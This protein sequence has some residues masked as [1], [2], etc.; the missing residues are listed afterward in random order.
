MSGHT[1]V[2]TRT[3]LVPPPRRRT[4]LDVPAPRKRTRLRPRAALTVKNAN[5]TTVLH[6]PMQAHSQKPDEF[7]QFVESLC[8]APVYAELFQRAGRDGWHGHGD[9]AA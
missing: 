6:A 3:R 9:E 5:Q 2:R 7:Y 1:E 4:R 8:P